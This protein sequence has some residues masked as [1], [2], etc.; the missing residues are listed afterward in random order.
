MMPDQRVS[1]RTFILCL[2]KAP[3]LPA[4]QSRAPIQKIFCDGL[5]TLN[6]VRRVREQS[7]IACQRLSSNFWT[8]FSFNNIKFGAAFSPKM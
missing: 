5:E 7:S 1:P 3:P 8:F 2:V 4:E 6:I